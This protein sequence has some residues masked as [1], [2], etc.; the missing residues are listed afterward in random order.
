M[1][2]TTLILLVLIVANSGCS[3]EDIKVISTTE[4]DSNFYFSLTLNGKS[5]TTYGIYK[6]NSEDYFS[7]KPAISFSTAKDI[8]GET[9]WLSRITVYPFEFSDNAP[10][11]SGNCSADILLSKYGSQ[12]GTYK[13]VI[14]PL[15]INQFYNIDQKN[16]LILNSTSEINI[17]NISSTRVVTG[18]FKCSVVDIT[19]PASTFLP[20]VGSFRLLQQ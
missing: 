20:A 15:S 1:K 12:L 19:N 5:Y 16:Y 18:S 17:E 6:N 3:K 11:R 14:E 8:N 9:I 10:W 4:I 7:M 13:I 2:I